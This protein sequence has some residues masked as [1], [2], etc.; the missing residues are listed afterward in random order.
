VPK[1]LVVLLLL[2]EEE[3]GAEVLVRVAVVAHRPVNLHKRGHN[4]T[5]RNTVWNFLKR[6]LLSSLLSKFCR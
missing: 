4:H 1:L 5:E 3:G 6:F 2:E